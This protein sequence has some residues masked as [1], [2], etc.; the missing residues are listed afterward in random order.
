MK[1]SV[2][3]LGRIE[4]KKDALVRCDDQN[5]MIKSPMSAI[6]IQHPVLGNVLYDTGNHP[7]YNTEYCCLLARPTLYGNSCLLRMRLRAKASRLQTLT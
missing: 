3:Y 4:C 5:A 7:L 1:I 2:L 6:L